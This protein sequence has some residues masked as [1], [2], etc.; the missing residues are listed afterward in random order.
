VNIG[1]ATLIL[2]NTGLPL[3]FISA[4]LS[5]LLSVFMIMGVVFNIGMQRK[6]EIF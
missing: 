2:P 4:G 6:S 3:P 1:V 5:S